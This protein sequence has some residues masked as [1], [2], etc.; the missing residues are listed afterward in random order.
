MIYNVK[1]IFVPDSNN[2]KGFVLNL[3]NYTHI[4]VYHACRPIDIRSYYIEG[5]KPFDEKEMRQAAS[6]IFGISKEIV[7]DN[8]PHMLTNLSNNVYFG[9]FKRE[10]LKNSGHYLCWGS[11]YL[12]SIAAQLD[13]SEYGMFHNI[14]SNTGI[15]TIFVCDIPINLLPQWQIEDI[16][17]HYDPY[18]SNL[19]CWIPDLLL[20]EYISMH[21][22]PSSIYNPVQRRQYVNKQTKCEYCNRQ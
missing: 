20:P 22:H 17:E 2:K 13:K 10:L 8:E 12:A 4:R 5:I 16:E 18:N 3:D 1:N 11:E 15:P 21:E 7:I 19:S 6:K 9:L 14:L